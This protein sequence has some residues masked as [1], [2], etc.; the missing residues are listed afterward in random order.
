[1]KLKFTCLVTLF[2]AFVIQLSFAQEKTITGT[3]TAAADGL[4]LPGVNVIVK[5]TTRGA[6]SDFDGKYSIQASQGET[7]VFSYIGLVSSEVLIGSSNNY[8]VQMIEDIATL[9][10]VVVTGYASYRKSEVTGSAVQLDNSEITDI[11]LPS[12][13]QALQG[14]VAGLTVSGDSGTP[15]STSQIRI[16]GISSITAGNEPLYVID[17]VPVNSGNISSSGA[18]SFFSNLAAF[19][20]N[21]IE[22]I[23]VLKDASSTAQYGARGANGVILITTK[24]GKQ[25]KTRFTLSTTYGIQNDAVDGPDPLTA[26]N[27]LELASEA[28]FN[29]GFFSTKADAEAYLLARNPFLSWDQAGR[30]EGNWKDAI[31]NKDAEIKNYNLSASGGNENSNFFVSLGYMKQEGTV[32]GSAFERINGQ[33]NFST[34]FSDKLKF[35]TNNSGAYTEQNAFLERSAYFEGART[36]PFFMSPLNIPY[37]DDGTFNE[38]G[39]SLPNPLY[40]VKY[41]KNDNL[42]ARIV[43]N[44]QLSWD[45]GHGFSASTRFNIDYQVYSQRNY[46]NRNYGYGVPVS[47]SASQYSR[48][49][50]T[51]TFQNQLNYNFDIYEDHMFDVT[52]V[53][54]YAS[55]RSYFVGGYGENFADDGLYY[56]DSLGNPVSI[57]SSFNDN[58]LGAYLGT[59]HY[60]GFQG[61]YVFDASFRYEGNSRF[62][63][64]QRWGSFWSVGGAWNMHKEDFINSN[65]WL[66]LLKLRASYGTTGNAN[67]GTN[68]Y[69]SL[70]SFGVDY[71]SE[72]A[73]VVNTFGNKDLSWEKSSTL[74]LGIEFGL[75]NNVVNG[76]VN[77]FNREST[78]L[79]LNVPLSQT[80]GFASQVQNIGALTNKGFELELNFNVI[81]RDDFNLSI[82]GNLGTVENEITKLPLDPNGIERTIT[83]TIDRIETGH[84]V[85][86]YYMPTWAGVN[87]DTGMEE[88]YINGVDGAKTTVFNDADQV[89]QGGSAI[90]KITA[91]LNL[92]FD[93][94]GFYLDA[95]GY[96]AGGHKIYEGWHRYTNTTNGFPV[97]AYQGLTTLLDRWQQP[98]D[99][100]RFGKFTSAYTPWQRHSKYL[101]DGD[102]LRLRSMTIGYNFKNK[103]ESVGITNLNLYVRGNNLLTWVKDDNLLYD[104]EVDLGG[105]TGLETPPV[106][107]FSLGLILNF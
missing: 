54:E 12:V 84:P 6:Q 98:G 60:S 52:L 39:G 61:K 77:Y 30:P 28:Y 15:G 43:T 59:L 14:K 33:I 81:T 20:S 45:I 2:M 9:D 80:T 35:S 29:D 92:H 96:Y 67:I 48:N 97:F 42:L 3:I 101:Y 87:P 75:F 71:N 17:G 8:N 76:T 49:N 99:I 85:Y 34:N 1:M 31:T 103:F 24:S 53:Q 56:L 50:V 25:G 13:D 7:L 37:N 27:R 40:L 47:G 4:P 62:S 57:N 90:P 21:N 102:F 82:G 93:Y 51:Y 104:P 32:I 38:F 69:Q 16:R 88:Y 91:G 26:A 100:T 107:S 70:F 44:N 89:W 64:E 46:Q 23:T 10:E 63:P 58:Y 18:T 94:K 74:D 95:T 79:L 78:D 19:D 105:E 36:A 72:G 68:Q 5:G 83:S 55:N 65:D 11:I 22:T 66:N 41:N 86:G 73:Q 106:K